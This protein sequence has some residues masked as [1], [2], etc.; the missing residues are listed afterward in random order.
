MALK[1]VRDISNGLERDGKY[2]YAYPFKALLPT[3]IGAGRY[4]DMSQATGVPKFNAYVGDALTATQMTGSGNNGIYPGNFITGSTKHLARWQA[5]LLGAVVPAN[6]MLLDYLM[7]YPLIDGDSVDEQVMDNPVTLPRYSYGQVMLVCT[8]AGALNGSGT[9]LYRN[10]NGVQKSVNFNVLTP[11]QYTISTVV[12]L[13]ATDVTPFIPLA[14]GDIG[15]TAI[16]SITF[17]SAP[18]GFF[19]AVIVNVIEDLCIPEATYVTEKQFPMQAGL[20]P[21]IKPGAYLNTICK[22]QA[23]AQVGYRSEM[24]FINS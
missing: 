21:E 20:C 7:F 19:T 12:A 11:G 1:G 4:I 2:H 23:V 8:V 16:D 24:I 18:G 9:M 17:T 14:P 5:Q 10:Q 15:V 22:M 13:T 6:L 3:P